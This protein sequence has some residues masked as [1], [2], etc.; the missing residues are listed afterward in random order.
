M[1]CQIIRV[2]SSP[3]SSTTGVATLIFDTP[4]IPSSLL[5][6]TVQPRW[7]PGSPFGQD[8]PGHGGNE[9]HAREYQRTAS[10]EVDALTDYQQR[11][12]DADQDGQIRQLPDS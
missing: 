6:R 1:N 3:S 11:D 7:S 2:I 4:M 8:Q 12:A 9:Q 10:D 5:A